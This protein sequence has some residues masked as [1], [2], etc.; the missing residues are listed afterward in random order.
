M[1]IALYQ[2]DIAGNVGTILRLAACWDLGV[3]IVMP[4]GFTLEQTRRELPQLTARPEWQVL[5]AVRNRRAY[6]VDGN[7]YLNRPGPRIVDSGRAARKAATHAAFHQA[8]QQR[9]AGELETDRGQVV[10]GQCAPR[11][12]EGVGSH[13]VQPLRNSIL[14]GVLRSIP[15]CI[16]RREKIP[17]GLADEGG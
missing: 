1:R 14:S 11:R 16:I 2:P 12:I 13:P 5:P 10:G 9:Q 8:P 4:C 6:S 15:L 3:D 17:R 7:A